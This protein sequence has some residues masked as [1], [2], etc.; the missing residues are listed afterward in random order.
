[1][2]LQLLR[3]PKVGYVGV[4]NAFASSLLFVVLV[5]P[6]GGKHGENGE[7]A[8]H[9][10][11]VVFKNAKVYQKGV[12]DVN[13][14]RSDDF[15]A[16]V[17][18]KG[19]KQLD[20]RVHIICMRPVQRIT[21]KAQQGQVTSDFFVRF[22]FEM[23]IGEGVTRE[24]ELESE[25]INLRSKA[26]SAKSEQY[27]LF[28][29]SMRLYEEQLTDAVRNLRLHF[30]ETD[31]RDEILDKISTMPEIPSCQE[32]IDRYA[33]S[34][35]SFARKQL[36]QDGGSAVLLLSQLGSDNNLDNASVELAN[37]AASASQIGVKRSSPDADPEPRQNKKAKGKAAN[38]SSSSSSS[39][40]SIS[41]A[42][43]LLGTI[44]LGSELQGTPPPA[45]LSSSQYEARIASL[46]QDV[47]DLNHFTR[48]L[49]QKVQSLE[50][51]IEATKSPKG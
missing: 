21:I 51:L 26:K 34:K 25:T 20:E 36:L 43:G 40:S 11:S 44:G 5:A 41:T 27:K 1:M 6:A 38:S 16:S 22:L 28:R 7:S 31:S 37:F 32:Y 35:E 50:A 13:V 30:R 24:Y 23:K 19:N 29:D 18:D 14:D 15:T 3:Q 33:M 49:V 46:E 4:S 17:K 9:W 45:N 12:G 8:S 2:S 48:L 10:P 42:T 47:G 39:S